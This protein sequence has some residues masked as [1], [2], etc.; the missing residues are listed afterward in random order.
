VTPPRRSREPRGHWAIAGL[1]SVLLC[2]TLVLHGYATHQIGHTEAAAGVSGQSAGLLAGQALLDLRFDDVHSVEPQTRTVALTFDDGPD[3]RWTPEVLDVLRRHGVHATF[4]VVGARVLEHPD[5]TRRLLSEGHEIG[6]HTFS[7]VD[8]GALPG[9]E[10]GLQLSLT[11][12]A[13]AGAA[14][15]RPVLF[16]PPYASTPDAVSVNSLDAWRPLADRGYLIA[17]SDFDSK[18]WKRDGV[19]AIVQRATPPGEAGGVILFHD[20][21]GDRSETIAA[22]DRLLTSL[23]RRGYRFETMSSF[24]GLPTD[25]V[26]PRATPTQRMQGWMLRSTTKAGSELASAMHIL[27]PLLGLLALAR[28]AF[29]VWHAR[30]HR[31]EHHDRPADLSFTPSV[32]IVV[33]AYNEAVGISTTVTSLAGS[34]YPS[35]EIIVVDDGSVDDTAQLVRDL[36]LPNVRV[37]EQ[38]NMGKPAALNTGIA[39]ARGEIIVM[40]DGDT[41]FE[42]ET[43]AFLVQSFTDPTVGAVAGNTKVANRRGLLGQ[44][45]HIEYVMGFNLDRRMYEQLRCMP[46]VPGAIGAFRRAA[47]VGVRGVSADTLAED[48]DLTLAV[49]RAGWHV[50]YEQRA[51]AWTE[52]PATTRQM[53]KQRYRWSYGTM[54]AMWKHRGALHPADRSPIGWRALPYMLLFQ[55][56]LPLFAPLIDIFAIYGLLFLDRGPVIGAWLGFTAVQVLVGWYAFRLDGEPARPLLTL[57]LQQVVYRQLLYLVTIHS[58]VTAVLGSPL[59]WHKL[60][61]TGDFSAIP[62]SIDATG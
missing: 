8:V 24:A 4:F 52:A 33:P 11:Q 60:D 34:R 14:G 35:V 13:I 51:I 12:S 59:R 29:L 9:W 23:Q 27:L 25:A 7:H 50:V 40:V 26:Q 44:W 53:W 18:D 58:V 41:A 28:T 54:Q 36:A 47:L 46:T 1:L 2:A 32:S 19:A 22:L 31:R 20:G 55:V 16:R 39:A 45:Q 15:V 48:T 49:G 17:L 5:L 6:N 42:P 37:I 61:R 56:L 10:L 38:Q 3:P 21:G 57:P 43:L 62:H 30:R